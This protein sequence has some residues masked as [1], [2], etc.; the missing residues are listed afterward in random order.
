MGGLVGKPPEAV[1]FALNVP[2]APVPVRTDAEKAVRILTNLLTNAF[3]F[4]TAGEVELSVAH[5]DYAVTWQVRDTGIGIDDPDHEAVFDE[6]RQVDGSTTRLFGG[7]GLGLA[8]SRQLAELLSGGITLESTAGMGSTFTL[9]LP[10]GA[11]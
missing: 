6:F 1:R 3:K 5:D 4:T 7:T 8:L 2:E 9:R 11:T 10:V